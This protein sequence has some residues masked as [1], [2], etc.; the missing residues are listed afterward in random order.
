MID[1]MRLPKVAEDINNMAVDLV[2]L[3][4]ADLRT[5]SSRGLCDSIEDKAMHFLRTETLC[6]NEPDVDQI[7]QLLTN[8]IERTPFD[9]M[10]MK[11][12]LWLCELFA[13]KSGDKVRERL[14]H[15]QESVID[16]IQS[17]RFF[18]HP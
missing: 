9:E 6:G 16:S 18:L 2:T 1:D 10:R 17:E 15:I 3:A 7:R 4:A 12:H 14:L 8:E 11:Y 13:L 5:Y